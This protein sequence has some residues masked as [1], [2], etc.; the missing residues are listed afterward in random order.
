M[1]WCTD[2]AVDDC[3]VLSGCRDH[4][5]CGR[6]CGE[7]SG[8]GWKHDCVGGGLKSVKIYHINCLIEIL[9]TDGTRSRMV[10]CNIS[11]RR[12]DKSESR[13]KLLPWR[14]I[15][16]PPLLSADDLPKLGMH[17]NQLCSF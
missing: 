4:R 13:N 6:K 15:W 12:I 5:S 10:R 16:K 11:S 17:S 8:G 9:K 7:E 3:E 2:L 14:I 1:T